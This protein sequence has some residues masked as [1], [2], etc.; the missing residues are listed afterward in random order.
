MKGGN[1]EN[2]QDSFSG[3]TLK[4]A[5]DAIQNMN[6]EDL[7]K[8]VIAMDSIKK[9]FDEL[10]KDGKMDDGMKE[11]TKMLEQMQKKGQ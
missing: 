7:K 9:I 10:N 8:A 3:E 6:E 2:M 1:L 5:T 11:S 4:R